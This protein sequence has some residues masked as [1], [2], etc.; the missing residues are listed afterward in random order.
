MRPEHEFARRCYRKGFRATE[1]RLRIVRHAFELNDGFTAEDLVEAF[2]NQEP[3]VS[4]ATIYRTLS[5]PVSVGMLSQDP[6]AFVFRFNPT[7]LR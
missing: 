5:L 1:A 4:R 6:G 2:A 7:D 3:R